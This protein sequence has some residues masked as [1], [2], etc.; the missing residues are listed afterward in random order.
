LTF[1]YS[2]MKYMLRYEWKDLSLVLSC[3]V[4]KAEMMMWTTLSLD[5]RLEN[6]KHNIANNSNSL[7]LA[8]FN[9]R[10]W[11]RSE[12]QEI[13]HPKCRIYSI[14]SYL[15]WFLCL[16]CFIWLCSCSSLSGAKPPLHFY[17]TIPALIDE[18]SP[19]MMMNRWT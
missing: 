14:F 19:E 10:K 4:L 15:Y 18:D 16:L 5:S 9:H 6:G 12:K 7:I 1:I 2:N 13:F 3:C 11:Q 17:A 8:I